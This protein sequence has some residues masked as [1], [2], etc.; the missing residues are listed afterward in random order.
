MLFN[1]LGYILFLLIAV[2]LYWL[3]PHSKRI[4]ALFPFSILF[5]AMW[6]W[7]FALLMIFSACVDYF[8]SNKIYQSSDRIVRKR[9]LSLSLII[10]LGLLI[11][12][13]YTYF[14]YDKT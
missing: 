8:S 3:L 9:W 2:S 13:K 11:I 10:N 7:E 1:S 4:Y 6:R 12:F 14:I 5:Y